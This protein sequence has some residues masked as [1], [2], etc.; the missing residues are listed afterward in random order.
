MAS[1]RRRGVPTVGDRQG[2]PRAL[3]GDA[4]PVESEQDRDGG[5]RADS[6]AI[7]TNE[8]V[9]PPDGSLLSAPQDRRT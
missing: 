6:A 3:G 7:P 8:S 4:R 9:N 5:E 1:L 2:G